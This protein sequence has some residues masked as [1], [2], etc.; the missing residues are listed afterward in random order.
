MP[1]H[2]L[3]LRVLRRQEKEAM[4]A[5]KKADRQAEAEENRA[6]IKVNFEAFRA[7]FQ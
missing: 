3:R 4:K 5:E 7:K 6:K 1:G 2:G